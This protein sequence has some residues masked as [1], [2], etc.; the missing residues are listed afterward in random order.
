MKYIS[1]IGPNEELKQLLAKALMVKGFKMNKAFVQTDER[2]DPEIYKT[3]NQHKFDELVK[4]S[5]IIL[6]ENLGGRRIGTA[7]PFG[8]SKYVGLDTNNGH[9]VLKEK[10][11]KQIKTV[12]V[13]N[14]NEDY[15]TNTYEEVL[16]GFKQLPSIVDKI[17][18]EV[19]V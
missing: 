10:Y 15:G 6:V 11:G 9:S 1:I 5:I 14:D 4:R 18:Q 3:V 2:I 13:G 16:T 12:Y 8:S 7:E 17:I 19:A